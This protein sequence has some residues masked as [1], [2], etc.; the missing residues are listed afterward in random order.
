M[1]KQT[2]VKLKKVLI[3]HLKKQIEKKNKINELKLILISH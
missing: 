2:Q 1:K 3:D